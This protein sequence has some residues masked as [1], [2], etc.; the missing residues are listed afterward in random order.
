MTNVEPTVFESASSGRSARGL[1]S[2]LHFE[3]KDE[4]QRR[5][6]A[7]NMVE[8][9]HYGQQEFADGYLA[10]QTNRDAEQGGVRV[11][12]QAHRHLEEI[13]AV[14][15]IVNKASDGGCGDRVLAVHIHVRGP[16]VDIVKIIK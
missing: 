5:G 6:V 15:M 13:K 1:P 2:D 9:D 8:P 4:G 11:H 10:A 12:G 16:G 14:E 7:R 3:A